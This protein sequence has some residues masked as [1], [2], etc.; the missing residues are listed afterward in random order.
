M[1]LSLI[2]A[3]LFYRSVWGT[4]IVAV[5]WPAVYWSRKKTEIKKQQQRLQIQ[6]K[7]CLRVVTAALYAGYSVENAF[8]EAEKELTQLLGKQAEMCRELQIINQQLR[9]NIP[10]EELL[11]DL[12]DRSGVEE[13]YSFGQV[14]GYA[15]RN[16]SDFL[17]VLKDTSQRIADK[18]DLEREI[19]TMV[20]AKRLEQKIMNVIP[21]GIL[22]FVDITSPGFLDIMYTG[23]AGRVIMSVCLLVYGAA[24]LLSGRIVDIRV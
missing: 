15:K 1:G 4:A 13:I 19:T 21:M 20:A 12:A 2:I 23:M 9:L 6:F 8:R 22:L 14:F 5:V 18:I 16:G 11:Q 17:H 24:Y 7:E 10:V 3:R